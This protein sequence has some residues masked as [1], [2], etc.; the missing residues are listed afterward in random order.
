MAFGIDDAIAAGLKVIDKFVPDPAAKAKAE[1]ELRADLLASDRAQME[2]NK[3]EA[4]TG[5]LF[6]GGWRPAIGW[7]LAAAVAYTYLIVPVGMW[8]SFVVG[9]PIAKPPVLDANLWELMFAMLGLGGLRTFEKIK[10][11]ASK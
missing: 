3:A 7:V 8:V 6:I 2:V 10:G 5:S 1:A 11:V 9:K 4:Q